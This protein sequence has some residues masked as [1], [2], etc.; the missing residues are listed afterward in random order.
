VQHHNTSLRHPVCPPRDNVN[1]TLLP[2]KIEADF[3][4]TF[5]V[6]ATGSLNRSSVLLYP[7]NRSTFQC[8]DGLVLQ[9][10]YLTVAE[11][12]DAV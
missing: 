3:L 10:L 5:I 7:K 9:E 6:H 1:R 8:S 4:A 2:S 11:L 12:Q